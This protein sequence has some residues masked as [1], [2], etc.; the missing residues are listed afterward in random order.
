MFSKSFFVEFLKTGVPKD[1][2]LDLFSLYK[3]KVN[4]HKIL[5]IPV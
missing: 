3:A 5:T 1:F 4:H 2:S